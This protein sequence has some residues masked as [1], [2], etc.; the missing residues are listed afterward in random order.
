MKGI[1]KNMNP[2]ATTVRIKLADL[3]LT[4]LTMKNLLIDTQ[5]FSQWIECGNIIQAAAIAQ[6]FELQEYFHYRVSTL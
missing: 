5:Q 1:L 6:V 3:M 4:P 2:K